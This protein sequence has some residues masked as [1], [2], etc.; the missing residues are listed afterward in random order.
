MPSRLAQ[1]ADG[2]P[3]PG[4]EETL[5]VVDQSHALVAVDEERLLRSMDREVDRVLQAFVEDEAAATVVAVDRTNEA[6]ATIPMLA[7]IE[8]AAV[9]RQAQRVQ[10]PT[11]I[12]E[13]QPRDLV[14]NNTRE[15]AASGTGLYGHRRG[16]EFARGTTPRAAA[17]VATNRRKE[18]GVVPREPDEVDGG[19]TAEAC[20]GRNPSACEDGPVSAP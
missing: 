1:V 15:E 16:Q 3:E 20:S 19:M 9:A 17:A 5:D 11:R 13:G 14:R 6:D 12:D 8:E 7:R 18:A 10:T 4:T 2:R